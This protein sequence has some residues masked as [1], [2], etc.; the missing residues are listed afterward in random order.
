MNASTRNVKKM[1]ALLERECLKRLRL[2]QVDLEEKAQWEKEEF[3]CIKQLR[4]KKVKQEKEELD[5]I[6]QLCLEQE[7]RERT[8]LEGDD[9]IG[10]MSDIKKHSPFVPACDNSKSFE[11]SF[12]NQ[13]FVFDSDNPYLKKDDTE[14]IFDCLLHLKKHEESPFDQDNPR[15]FDLS[16][17]QG[18]FVCALNPS[19]VSTTIGVF[20]HDN[21]FHFDSDSI[22]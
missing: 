17:V 16:F 15:C 9:K 11:P 18:N 2:K 22:K 1:F 3:K 19:P 10:I 7:E 14:S 5:H 21:P 4:L 6:E 13:M 8:E 20:D 12:V